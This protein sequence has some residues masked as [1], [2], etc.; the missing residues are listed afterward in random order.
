MN[1]LKVKNKMSQLKN[2]RLKTQIKKNKRQNLHFNLYIIKKISIFPI[3]KRLLYNH[4]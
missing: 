1:F 4:G 3:L 2:E